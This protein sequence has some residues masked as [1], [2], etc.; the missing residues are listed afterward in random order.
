MSAWIKISD[1][2]PDNQDGIL[3]VWLRKSSWIE[4]GYICPFVVGYYAVMHRVVENDMEE[5]KGI[6]DVYK[7]DGAWELSDFTHWMPFPKMPE[8]WR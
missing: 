6:C 8:G 4:E 1:K 5:M 7:P 3:Q 2:L